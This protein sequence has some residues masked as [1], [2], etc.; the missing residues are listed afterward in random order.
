MNAIL[1]K[2]ILNYG[3]AV[4]SAIVCCALL[5]FHL[6]QHRQ[7]IRE[8]PSL[9]HPIDLVYTWVN[10]ADPV[11]VSNLN[12]YKT[13]TITTATPNRFGD[14]KE[15]LYSLRAVFRYMPWIRHIYIVCADY[16][17]PGYLHNT[18]PK[19]SFVKHSS[20]F[21]KFC[22]ALPV[23]NSNAIE[24]RVHKIPGLAEHYIYAN[25]DCFVGCPLEPSYFYQ[26]G[27]PRNRV[28]LTGVAW[29]MNLLAGDKDMYFKSISCVN[30]ILLDDVSPDFHRSVLDHQMQP[31]TKTMLKTAAER[32]RPQWDTTTCSRFRR[33]GDNVIHHLAVYHGLYTDQNTIERIS[34]MQHPVVLIED[35]LILSK[36]VLQYISS[37]RP[38]LFCLNDSSKKIDITKLVQDFLTQYYSKLPVAPWE[39]TFTGH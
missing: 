37:V 29:I 35:N 36:V 26:G 9:V 32:F 1:N 13:C 24:S 10:G 21:G 12:F 16:Q 5:F 34:I 15:L 6:A 39:N 27:T 2:K 19:L 14:H 28:S 31:L 30:D 11:H 22:H 3:I 23:F 25:D 33:E 8:L 18:H 4:A 17:T 7:T 38:N 20:I